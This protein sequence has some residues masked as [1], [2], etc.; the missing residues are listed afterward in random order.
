MLLLNSGL[1]AVL[2][3]GHLRLPQTLFFSTATASWAGAGWCAGAGGVTAVNALLLG[4]GVFG[5]KN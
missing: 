1:C 2:C 3:V 4:L 5:G